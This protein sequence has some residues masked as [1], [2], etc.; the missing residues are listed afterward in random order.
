MHGQKNI[1]LSGTIILKR[2]HSD[3]IK[4]YISLHVQYPLLFSDFKENCIPGYS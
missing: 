1:K 4:I 2:I 3:I